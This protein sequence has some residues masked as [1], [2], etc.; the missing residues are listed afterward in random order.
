MICQ[1]IICYK[2]PRHTND[3]IQLDNYQDAYFFKYPELISY[4]ARS[5]TSRGCVLLRSTLC[6]KDRRAGKTG[7]SIDCGHSR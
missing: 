1:K 7:V 6:V 3:E 5:R 2:I 4:D